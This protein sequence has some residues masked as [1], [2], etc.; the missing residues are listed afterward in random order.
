MY[1]F[2][3]YSVEMAVRTAG[4]S[5]DLDTIGMYVHMGLERTQTITCQNTTR[6]MHMHMVNTLIETMCDGC[7]PLYWRERCHRFLRKLKPLLYEMLDEQTYRSKVAEIEMLSEYFLLPTTNVVAPK[8]TL[9]HQR[10]A[11]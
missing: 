9:T 11:N 7:I 2:T 5:S 8:G 1:C 10:N 4:N 3:F 6:R